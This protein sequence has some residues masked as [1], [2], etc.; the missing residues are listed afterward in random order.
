MP[1]GTVA[2]WNTYA[3]ARG[4]TVPA[5]PQ[6]EQALQ[7]ADD[8]IR[9]AYVANFDP[10][11]DLA[12]AQVV[13]DLEEAVYIAAGFEAKTA[14]FFSATF[15][16]SQQKVLTKVGDIGWT[17]PDSSEGF[18]AAEASRPIS[19]SVDGLLRKYMLGTYS[20][21]SGTVAGLGAMVV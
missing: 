19:T 17:L 4:E 6:D 10:A 12:E 8:Y 5:S 11:V 21:G 13:A 16:P 1:Y 9:N 15:T 7:R 2:G 3:S 14:N 20:D 18:T